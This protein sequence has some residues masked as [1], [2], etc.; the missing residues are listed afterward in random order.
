MIDRSPECPGALGLGTSRNP[1]RHTNSNFFLGMT[2]SLHSFKLMAVTLLGAVFLAACGGG[3]PE[4]A[5][6]GLKV[7][8]GESSVTVTWDVKPGV[9]T[10]LFFAPT[11]VAPKDNSN[12][13][14]WF[15]LYGGNV[16][17]NVTPPY[18]VSGLANALDY[19][20]TLNARSGGG[21]GGPAAATVTAQARIAGASWTESAS[22]G[23]ADLR[24]LVFGTSYI[25][26]GTGGTIQSSPDGTTWTGVTSPV[27]T[28]LNGVSYYGSYRAVGDGGALLNS[29]DGITWTAL[30]SGTSQNLNAISTNFASLYV[31]VGAGGTIITSADGTTWT[32][33]TSSGTSADL[34]AV[35]YSTYNSGTWLAV[36][37]NGTMVK[38]TDG[39]TWTAVASGTTADLRGVTYGSSNSAT[40]ATAFAVVGAGGTVLSS[41]DATVWTAQV[42]PGTR[43]MTAVNFGS[44]FI[45]VGLGG[46]IFTSTDATTWTAVAPVGFAKDLLSLARGSLMVA[47]VGAAGANL[48]S[49]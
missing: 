44:Q 25:A 42:L 39:L 48:I 18:V 41:A 26:V 36:G 17:L 47:A 3:S 15:G 33:A 20:F 49:K 24:G 46:A 34:Y 37:A 30:T 13:S 16:L 22:S 4:A 2:M 31:A 28:R 1:I 14:R 8:A 12:M 45:A 23:A 7:V 43:T 27:T 9:E 38:S 19:S 11:A 32:P 29:A 40:G 6:T 35:A 5:P 21:P 10:W